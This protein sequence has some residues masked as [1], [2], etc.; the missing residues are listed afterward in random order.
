MP[1][2]P[3]PSRNIVA[4]SGTGA[5][6]IWALRFLVCP[7]LRLITFCTVKV[8]DPPLYK[9]VWVG[10]LKTMSKLSVKS[11][12]RIS[13]F[14]SAVKVAGLPVM[15]VGAVKFTRMVNVSSAKTLLTEKAGPRV[16]VPTV[17]VSGF[18]VELNVWP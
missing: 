3:V 8:N 17:T 10:L 1:A 7:S 6:V 12:I 4:G 16:K 5:E 9:N 14:R 18:D 11:R 2:R 13:P 15:H